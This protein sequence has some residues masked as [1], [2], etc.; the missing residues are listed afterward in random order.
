MAW[1]E[2]VLSSAPAR[3]AEDAANEY[4][5]VGVFMTI[6]YATIVLSYCF[7]QDE[8]K[9][10][11][12]QLAFWLYLCELCFAGGLVAQWYRVDYDSDESC[13]VLAMWNQF[14]IFAIVLWFG[15]M[16]VNL[17]V[18]L[19]NPWTKYAR[20]GPLYHC[21][22]WGISSGLAVHLNF[23]DKYGVSATGLCWVKIIGPIGEINLYKWGVCF[24]PLVTIFLC[25]CVLNVLAFTHVRHS[26]KKFDTLEDRFQKGNAKY[27]FATRNAR[28]I[29]VFGVCLALNG[30][31]YCLAWSRQFD[32]RGYQL[33]FVTIF[34]LRPVLDLLVWGANTGL[35]KRLRTWLY[36]CCKSVRRCC[37]CWCRRGGAGYVRTD[38]EVIL[39]EP[40]QPEPVSTSED[41]DLRY[42]R[43]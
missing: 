18:T 12:L 7:V 30:L 16:S 2:A 31:F 39:V 10:P 11:A 37:R 3:I 38:S 36:S 13:R 24:T 6:I 35:L 28:Y 1:G 42:G 4:F 26:R 32:N 15:V 23:A 9:T 8:R 29:I 40:F 41:N 22:I 34:C 20:V 27:L 5:T 25:S 17:Y 14:F 21:L 33:G 43:G 19:K